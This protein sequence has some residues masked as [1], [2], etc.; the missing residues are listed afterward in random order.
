MTQVQV[1]RS[2]SPWVTAALLAF[3]FVLMS[4]MLSLPLSI[5]TFLFQPFSIPAGSMAPTLLVGDN[6]FV[7]KYAYG[8]SRY[9]WPFTSPSSGRIWGSEPA[10]GDVVAFFSPK[11]NSTVYIKRVVGLPGDH[12]QMKQGLL[13][14]NGVPVV[15]ERSPDFVGKDPCGSYA[16][17]RTRRWRETLPNGVS[18]ETL[19]CVDNGFYDNTNDYTVP[20]GHFFVLGDNRDNSIDS[21]VLTQIGYVPLDNIIGR[22]GMIYFSVGSDGAG[23]AS[24]FRTERMG[25]MIH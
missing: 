7:S 24:R 13:H 20:A 4:V 8:Y 16:L 12:I 22:A 3:S 1:A 6:F 15:R 5:R 19:D 23:A 11:D 17:T 21:R 14:L 10:R 18:H 2:E 9:T 25:L